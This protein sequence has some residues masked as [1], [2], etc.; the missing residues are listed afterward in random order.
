[1]PITEKQL[2]GGLKVPQF[3]VT[4]YSSFFLAGAFYFFWSGGL[5]AA[6]IGRTTTRSTMLHVGIQ[7][8]DPR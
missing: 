1:M 8:I 3:S 4:D 5:D 7:L 6:L 2:G